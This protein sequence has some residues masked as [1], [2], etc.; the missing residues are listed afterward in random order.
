MFSLCTLLI[1][2]NRTTEKD[3]SDPT[4]TGDTSFSVYAGT[5]SNYNTETTPN[6]SPTPTIV[7]VTTQEATSPSLKEPKH[8]RPFRDITI[9]KHV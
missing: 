5:V 3:E 6:L 8:G 9:T 4:T 7:D 2:F 1:N